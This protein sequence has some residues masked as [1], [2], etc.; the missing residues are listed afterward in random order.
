MSILFEATRQLT[1]TIQLENIYDILTTQI[2]DYLNADRCS[3]LLLN[4]ARTHFHLS[5]AK[6]R[7]E[8]SEPVTLP[9]AR[10]AA[11]ED[12]PLLQQ[13]LKRPERVIQHL[14]DLGLDAP[15]RAFM[16][17]NQ[18]RLVR[19]LTRF[20]L[21]VR[22]TLI[23]LMEVEHHQQRHEYTAN[24]LQLAQAIISQVTV[25]IE[26]AQLFEQTEAALKDTQKLYDISRKLVEST[27][28]D[29]VFNTILE[30]VRSYDVDRVSIS[31][32]DPDHT[33]DDAT[34]IAASWDRDP[35]HRLPVGT[36]FS[37]SNF[38]L[39][40]TFA[41]PPF[42]PL[43]SHNLRSPENQDERLDEAFREYTANELGAVT[44]FSA[45]MFLGPTYKGVL[46]IYTRSP[47]TYSPQ[48]V[49]VYQTLA[50]QAII[51]IEN[52]R[53]LQTTRQE[54]DRASLLYELGQTLS[55]T[56]SVGEVQ[57]VVLNFIES[58]GATDGELYITDGDEFVSLASTIR[59]R[60]QLPRPELMAIGTG[61]GHE[62]YALSHQ[63]LLSISIDDVPA[64]MWPL[65]NTKYLERVRSF[66]CVPFISQRSTL[67]GVLSLYHDEPNSFN[68]D[69][70]ATLQSVA[71]Q[72]A[73]SLE[74]AWL[75]RQTNIVLHETELLYNITRGFNAAQTA[76]DLLRV[77]AQNL[78]DPAIDYM[79]M[80]LIPGL[81][82]NGLPLRVEIRACW[83]KNSGEVTASALVL[84][85]ADFEFLHQFDSTAPVEIFYSQQKPATQA[86]IDARLFGLRS[87]LAVPL[88]VGGNWLGALLLGS[89]FERYAFKVNTIS[90]TATLASQAAVVLQNLQLVDETQQNLVYS[91][92]MSNLGQNLLTADTQ[93]AIYNLTLGAIA[94]TEPD[95]GAA[96]FMYD[97]I[98]SSVELELVDV[99]DY[100][101][102]Q[103]PTIPV[104]SR[105]SAA[106]LGLVPLLRTGLT[107]I[108]SNGPEDERFSPMLRQ[109]LIMMQIKVMVAVP[110][111][112][113]KQ[114]NGFLLVGN[115]SSTA[116]PA[117]TIRLY[118][119][120][121]REASGALENRRLFEEAQYRAWQL[122]T[123]ADIS[124]AATA[125]L[126]LD[127][128]LFETVEMIKARFNFYHAS[129][130]LVDDYRRYAVV[131]AS[132]GEIGQK[133]LEMKH[134]LEV[135]GKSIV[136][137]ATGTAKPRIALDVGKDAVHFNNP[138]LPDTRSEMALPLVAQGRVIGALDVQS[139]RRGA[140]KQTDVTILQSMANQLA[141]A[142]EAA[143]AYRE[144]TRALEEVQKIHQ[145]YLQEQ[146]ESYLKEKETITGFQLAE[147]GGVVALQ[148]APN[149]G[150]NNSQPAPDA[151]LVTPL[152]PY[153]Q[154]VIGTLEL[155]LPAA[156]PQDALDSELL[157]IVEA[158]SNQAAQAIEAARL[159]EQTQV[160]RREA[161]ALYEVGRILVATE[162]ETEMFNTV[163]DKMLSTMGLKQ[164]GILFFNDDG[165][166][167]R[168]HALFRDGQPVENPQVVIPIAGNMSYEKLIETKMPVA[169]DDFATDPLVEKVR[170]HGIS[171]SI[172]SLLLVPIVI[173]DRVVGA[174]G[175]DAVEERHHFTGREMNLAKAMADQLAI[176]LQNR[177][178]IKETQ[179][180]AAL[181][182][183][184]SDV[185]R[186]AT[187]IL[188]ENVMMDQIVELIREG[189]GFEHAEIYLM[190]SAGQHA[191]LHKGDV[192]G[193][194]EKIA[195]GSQNVVGQ[196][197][198]K[199]RAIMARATDDDTAPLVANHRSE[200]ESQLAVPLQVGGALIGALSVHTNTP[201]GFTGEEI[202]T[203]ETLAAQLAVAIQNARAF[204]EQQ[205]T[206]ERL[207][208][209]DKL[210]TQFLANMSHELRTPLNSII[211]FSR[212]IIKGI[213]GPLTEMQ[214]ADLTSIH[215]S[216]QHL[217]GLIN[218]ILDLSKI[219]AGKME[220]NF[221]EADIEPIIKTV[222]STA[223]ALVKD[224]PVT[225]KQELPDNLPKIWADPTRVRQIILNLV[226]N[227]CKFTD[228]GEVTTRVYTEPG[229]VVFTVSDTGIGIPEE[230]LEHI[231]EEFT[232]VDASTTRKVGGTGL[233]LPISRHFVEMHHGEIWVQSRLG[234]GTTFGFYIPTSPPSKK[235]DTPAI[236][237]AFDNPGFDRKRVVVAIDDDP[238]VI[239]LYR[240]FLEQRS[241]QVVGLNHGKNAVSRIKEIEPY[242]ILLDIIIPEKDGWTVIKELKDDPF[243]KN[244]PVIICSIVSDKN[245]GFSL[246]ATN[247]LTKPI[248]ENELVEALKHLDTHHKEETRVLVVDDQADDVLLIRRILEAQSNHTIFEAGN[249][250]E[251]LELV[252]TTNPD[253]IIMDLNMP[254]MD[255]FAMIEALKKNEA[256]RHIPIVIVSAQELTAEEQNYLT[257]QVEVLLRKGLFS[258][259]ELLEDVAQALER[260]KFEEKALI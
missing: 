223:I 248:I 64:D 52:Y 74:N 57:N 167:G 220:L 169:I 112:I 71:I 69:Q 138:L 108:S 50:D 10:I 35:S 67:Q 115:Q 114:V 245:R 217:L 154:S 249:G 17:R 164:G 29:D 218:N 241:Y 37:G 147:D 161:E 206:A 131:R 7:S 152:S 186:V 243:T 190:D 133:M 56:T 194:T 177:R 225:L 224:K 121:G 155:V 195:G 59:R 62:A 179:R 250:K 148:T 136:G 122:Q 184:S 160:S 234:Y 84:S 97:Q 38:S 216:G 90:Q 252:A 231:F 228:E 16:T 15:T 183:T 70:V 86:N 185:G 49:R 135:G 203:L 202:S 34:V 24:E 187:S 19:T 244:I 238:G 96:I 30:T 73:T 31:L 181:L 222:M 44:L 209:I 200:F 2:M 32:I 53:L 9:E 72:T 158:V 130:F 119:D 163:L 88:S 192:L 103:W 109:L 92:V 201:S 12:F 68:E 251:G 36:R 137:A 242:A 215:N 166:T 178:L 123:A 5:L 176:T 159:F 239:E 104:G 149:A 129:I 106:E 259:K 191:V 42:H 170:K 256:T 153:G 211:G 60:Q 107:V 39:V 139:T 214:K 143:R 117:E 253:L 41:K 113:N 87:I 125:Y 11:V 26:N 13:M 116:F 198:A 118:E 233:G 6:G 208:E 174:V 89:E 85:A 257:G 144:S 240:R 189:F 237:A 255:G 232:Q 128:L 63:E 141:N 260:L 173:N 23:G 175:A 156:E 140:F 18:E 247:Y 205:E 165:E 46:S 79:A 235:Q 142:I 150:S 94:A 91:E 111:W 48:E 168:L 210:K 77:M 258:E 58:L 212:V 95:R 101:G 65:A 102:Q 54:R 99:W 51:A 28:I 98:E 25:A 188:D 20:P 172:A 157:T 81:D 45:P 182:Q 229:R 124:Q 219:E 8:H 47:H 146:W 1:E 80:G 21:I 134:K 33:D 180:R 196:A 204:R 76:A 3:V 83:Q 4:P 27:S 227:A 43:I 66:V 230:K 78:I 105:L 199:R 207:K 254:E 93:E 197:I 145:H 236:A 221:E 162:N 151:R 40:K 127:T 22:S 100:P 55:Q 171:T 120:I 75:L 61:N 82:N 246:G 213:D 193:L 226:S 14:N 132:T 126:D 110:L